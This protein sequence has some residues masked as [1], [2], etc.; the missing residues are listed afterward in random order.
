MELGIGMFGD[1]HYD[2]QGN[3]MDSGER[4]RELIDEIKLMDEVGLDFFGIGEHHRPDYA[5]SVPEIVLAAAAT[6]TKKIKLGSA[7]TVLS[8][9]DPVRIY[10]SFAT[11]DQLTNGR[12]EVT[13]GRGSFIESFP[14]YGYELKEYNTLFEEKLDLL[15]KINQQNPVT[16]KGKLRAPLDHQEIWPRAVH[17]KLKIWVAVGGTPES[18]VRAGKLGLPVIFAIIGGNPAQFQ[19]LFNY[20]QEVYKQFKHDINAFEV[21]VHMHCFFGEDSEKAADE[22]YPVYASQ[23]NR[24]GRTRGWQ[25]YTRSQYDYG[26]GTNGH[27]IIGDANAAVD[28]ILEMHELFGL[29][30]FS[31]H[32][33]VGGP[34]HTSL[35]K[36]IEIFG[37]QIAPKVRAAIKQ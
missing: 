35:M 21:G 10:Q 28:K 34:S 29:T 4:L 25:P 13:A 33:D 22:Y 14:L 11:I 7:V 15:V 32:M 37:T 16:W 31:A 26:R 6:V 27:L 24:I 19:P 36:S 23:M 9:S 17:D 18:V 3:P 12:A 20:Y 30:R 1:N 5:V 2:L 8:S